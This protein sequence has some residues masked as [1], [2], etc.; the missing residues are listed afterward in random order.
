MSPN[1]LG[2]TGLGGKL[3]PEFEEIRETTSVGTT[4]GVTTNLGV[5]HKDGLPEIRTIGKS[6]LVRKEHL[7]V[8]R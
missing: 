8:G 5:L 7:Y 6:V 2:W 1:T 4:L 3:E